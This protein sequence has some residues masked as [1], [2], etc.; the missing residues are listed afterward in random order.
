MR[1]LIPAWA[2]L[3]V[4]L[5]LPAIAAAQ[6]TARLEGQVFDLN[7]KPDPD[8]TVTIK[9]PDTG[10]TWQVKADK[11]GRYQQLGLLSGVYEI[12]IKDEKENI[13]SPIG[14]I[15]IAA[16]QVT[17]L[18]I[19]L[20][21]ILGSAAPS[22]EEVKKKEEEENK[23]KNVKLHFDNGVKA[24]DDANALQTQI[25]TAAADQKGPLQEKRTADCQSAFTEFQQAEQGISPKEV[26]NHAVVL[27][28]LGSAA[29]CAAKYDDAAAAFQKAAE[30][31]P[32]AGYYLGAATN[33]ANAGVALTDPAA[34]QAKFT[35]ANAACEKAVALDPATGATCWK[36]L[37][38][39]L[40]NKGRQKEAVA[41]LQKAT[42]ADPKDAQA[43]YLLG[44]A[45]SAMIDTKQE[46]D[47]L[48]AV[49]PPGTVEAYQKCIDAAPNGPYAAPAK[50]MLDNLA[51]LSGGEATS[52]SSRKKKK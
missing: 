33:L 9:N 41:P 3:A 34:A 50:E 46:G 29:E 13:D 24:M 27:A 25:R 47:K 43:W 45:Y 39:V 14:K 8:V 15:R 6:G 32:Q 31:Q 38:I 48:I 11:D 17:P 4:A 52:V 42:Q 44:G 5:L 10:Q 21:D 36:N 40:T 16:D 23:F 22:A 51:Q 20:K 49:I 12:Y 18:N 1:R 28:R 26:K 30:L 2:A 7:G 35:D 19:K 37:G